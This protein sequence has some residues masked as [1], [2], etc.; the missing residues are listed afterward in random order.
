MPSVCSA[1]KRSDQESGKLPKLREGRCFGRIMIPYSVV[2]HIKNGGG[3]GMGLGKEYDV[4]FEI[5]DYQGDTVQLYIWGARE[6]LAEAQRRIDE[7]ATG[8]VPLPREEVKTGRLISVSTEEAES[9][10][11][12]LSEHLKQMKGDTI[13]VITVP[14]LVASLL[15]AME[16]MA[17]RDLE[18]NSKVNIDVGETDVTGTD[19]Y[20]RGVREQLDE[21]EV[22]I[23]KLV[24]SLSS[25]P[26]QRMK[27]LR[28]DLVE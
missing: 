23:M 22:R 15:N 7:L 27:V 3:E 26:A 18:K 10:P 14:N 16:G 2:S 24:E 28:N 11:S 9:T 12:N 8:T 4:D 19:L 20:I 21:A 25:E 5:G 17:I 1:V 6:S 13:A